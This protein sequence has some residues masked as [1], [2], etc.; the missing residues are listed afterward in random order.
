M[1]PLKQLL[2][3]RAKLWH[4]AKQILDKADAE[5]RE[6]SA[7]DN[8]AYERTEQEIDALTAKIDAR[9]TQSRRRDKLDKLQGQFQEELPRQT[10]SSQPG[11]KSPS[12]SE[13]LRFPLKNREFSCAPGSREHQ[14]AG[15]KYRQDFL[16]YVVTGEKQPLGLQS[17]VDPK[18]GVL[19]STQMAMSLIKFLDDSVFIR[20]LATVL[21]PIPNAVSLGCPSFDT[22][23]GDADWTP[24][25][26]ASDISEDDAAAF[27]SRELTPH[28]DTKL[29]KFSQKMLRV[30]VIDA[31]SF[32]TGRIGYKFG[33]TEEKAFLTGAGNNRPL[34]AFVASNDG[35]STG[36]DVT[37]SSATA[38][39]ADDLIDCLYNLK[40]GHMGQSTWVG[41]REWVKRCRKLK[42]GNGQ[43]LWQ[44]GLQGGQPSVIL[45]RPYVMSE[46][47]P[48]T[49]TTGLYVA[50]IANWKAGYWIVDSLELEIQRINELFTLKNQ[51]GLKAMK[52]TDGMPVLEE[53]FSRLKL[54]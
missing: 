30:G 49:F 32:L 29:V 53:A 19:A 15:D 18:G 7:E 39:T 1:E 21:P 27:G 40:A 26:P 35:V 52:E 4:D 47:A 48:S 22:D 44:P 37:A 36:R 34:G 5:K 51:I 25:V 20:T 28:L 41:S 23:V 54:A 11:T 46:F 12:T 33:V 2:D 24:E 42:D 14:R 3:A 8:Q 16:H 10:Q 45:E 31:E 38:F 6:L 17:A 13:L 43:Y 9:E 50:I